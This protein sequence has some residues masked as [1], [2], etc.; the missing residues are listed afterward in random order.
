MKISEPAEE[1]LG[2]IW[3]F[4]EDNNMEYSDLNQGNLELL[5]PEIELF[6]NGEGLPDKK[7]V[8]ELK[9]LK[10][11]E[12]QDKKVKLTPRGWEESKNVIRRHRLAEKLL[13]DVLGLTGE[14]METAAC[15]FEHIMEGRMEESIC[16]LLSHPQTCPHGKNIPACNCQN[17]KSHGTSCKCGESVKKVLEKSVLPLNEVKKGKSGQ[18][19]YIQSK[20]REN[21][22][23]ILAMGVLPGR[24][25][26]IIQTYPSYVFQMEHTQ[27]AIDREIARSIYVGNLE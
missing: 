15:N 10:L 12:F 24:K 3:E 13:H 4:L 25:L 5:Y 7:A 2:K 1:L 20:K 9:N 8:E 17:G 21:L 23:K 6:L 14:D 19:V 11:I 16:T 18:I 26:K 27:M 22:N